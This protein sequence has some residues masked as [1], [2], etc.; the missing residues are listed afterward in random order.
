MGEEGDPDEQ[1]TRQP[2]DLGDPTTW[3][4]RV[5][6][7]VEAFVASNP[8]DDDSFHQ[9]IEEEDEFRRLLDGFLLRAFHATRLLDHETDGIGRSGLRVLSE[10]LISERIE[11]ASAGDHITEDER[12]SL[13]SAHVFA[14]G[15]ARNREGQ[16][17]L[18]MPVEVCA[19]EPFG[20]NP[21]LRTWGGEAITMSRHGA[22]WEDRLQQLGRPAIVVA[23]LDLHDSASV[24]RAHPPVLYAFAGRLLGKERGT[25]VHY[26]TDVSGDHTVAVWQPG[27]SEYDRFP[28]LIRG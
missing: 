20:L 12:D 16:I 15:E 23:L 24:H 18:F 4:E 21:L 11:A 17:S 3:P 13:L 8:D 26:R 10:E 5:R 28:H 6:S 1:L 14:S 25:T 27:S 7:R 2:I 9:A 22:A 19:W